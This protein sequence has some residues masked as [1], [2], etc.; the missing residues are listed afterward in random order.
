M[1]HIKKRGNPAWVKGKSANPKG[2]PRG[3]T[4]LEAFSRNPD[5]FFYYHIRWYRF[6]FELMEPPFTFAAAARRAGYSPKSARFIGSRL[7]RNPVIREAFGELRE[8]TSSRKACEDW[9]SGKSFG[10][11]LIRCS[12]TRKI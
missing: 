10:M 12:R 3:Q 2:R 7:W 8:I 4:S 9:L 11:G 5:R 6:C 1:E